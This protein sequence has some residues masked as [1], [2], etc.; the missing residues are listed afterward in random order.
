M[1]AYDHICLAEE[2]IW[3]IEAD[4]CGGFQVDPQEI[5]GS[6]HQEIAWLFPFEN[7]LSQPGCLLPLVSLVRAIGEKDVFYGE[8]VRANRN[9]TFNSELSHDTQA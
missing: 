9:A 2:P 1:L 3:D 7:L 8:R 6:L 4:G 5:L